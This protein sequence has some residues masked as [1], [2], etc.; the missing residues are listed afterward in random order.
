V[1]KNT[2]NRLVSTWTDRTTAERLANLARRNER[3]VSAELRIAVRERLERE[4]VTA[5]A[6]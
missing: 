1:A 2:Q 3:S 5:E 4:L 6:A